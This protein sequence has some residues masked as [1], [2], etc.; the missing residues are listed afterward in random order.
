MDVIATDIMSLAAI[1]AA[2]VGVAKGFGLADK[3]TH[4][5]AL[6][7]AA[8]FV[9]VPDPVSAKL[10]LVSV[11]GLT[12]SGAYHYSKKTSGGGGGSGGN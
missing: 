1:V 8:A 4:L 5:V 3:W 11:I 2:F 7:I 9:L 10:T 6:V 12:A